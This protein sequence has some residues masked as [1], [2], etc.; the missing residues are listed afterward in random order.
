MPKKKKFKQDPSVTMQSFSKNLLGLKFMQ[1][2]TKEEAARKDRQQRQQENG[3]IGGDEDNNDDADSDEPFNS[4]LR[5]KHQCIV[6]PSYQFCERLRFGRFSFKG[7]NADI[8]SLMY[9]KEGDVTGSQSSRPNLAG[10][11]R[12][13]AERDA[14]SDENDD[15]CQDI[16]GEDEEA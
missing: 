4:K 9:I 1:R 14:S 6:N 16:D 3:A 10:E 13:A 2:A 12:T 11:K 7:M 8:E 5:N 15:D